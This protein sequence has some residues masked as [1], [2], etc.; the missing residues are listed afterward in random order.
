[1]LGG[2]R[3][4]KVLLDDTRVSGGEA[5]LRLWAHKGIQHVRV[6]DSNKIVV[7]SL[8]NKV[9]TVFDAFCN[10]KTLG[11]FGAIHAIVE[12]PCLYMHS[13]AFRL[14]STPSPTVTG[15]PT[16]RSVPAVSGVQE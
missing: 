6:L 15:A 5:A 2:A 14:R 10:G 16:V 13:P 12:E 1:M 11:D 9:C 3:S 7:G 4:G 8:D